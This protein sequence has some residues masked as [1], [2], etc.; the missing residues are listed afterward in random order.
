MDLKLKVCKGSPVHKI[1]LHEA[2][3]CGATSLIVGTSGVD[4]KIRSRTS[5]AKYCSRNLQKNVVSVICINNGKIVFGGESN[6]SCVPLLGRVDVKRP[7]SRR[8][9]LSKSPLSLPPQRLST[10]YS[11]ESQNVSMAMVSVKTR[12]RPESKSGW[13]VLRKFFCHGLI[14]PESSSGKKSSVLRRILS[15]PSRLSDAAIYPD[16]K[17]TSTSE[18]LTNLD[19]AR[20]DIVPYSVD[21]NSNLFSSKIFSEELNALTEKYSATCQLFSYH[22]LLLATNNFIPGSLCFIGLLISNS[23]FLL[24]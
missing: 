5:V 1:I 11:N 24:M 8:K 2:K 22:E 10:S 16:Q 20:G 4:H 17:P 13:A 3:S 15:L 18:C 9:K 14:L 23:L 7:R 21:N 12:E 19:P 6:A